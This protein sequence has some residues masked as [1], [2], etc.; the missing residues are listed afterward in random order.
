MTG[1]PDPVQV[2]ERALKRA[3]LTILAC[4]QRKRPDP[5][6][7]PA[8]DRYDGPSWQT[9]RTIY[10]DGANAQVAVL[11]ARFGLRDARWAT[12]PDY[13]TAMTDATADAMIRGSIVTRSPRPS[14]ARIPDCTGIHPACELASMAN[15]AA[16]AFRD[17]T[18]VGGHRYIRVLESWLPAF[19]A[20]GWVTPAAR[21]VI[22]NGPIGRMRQSIRAWLEEGAPCSSI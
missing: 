1:A 7:S 2:P 21:I 22:A 8:I 17:I 12:L 16:G 4:S 3:R 5:G 10:R 15:A 11:S 20:A 9:L 13:D 18:L 19:T 6:H 14:S